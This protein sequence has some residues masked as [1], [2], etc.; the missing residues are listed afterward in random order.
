MYE[1]LEI[2]ISDYVLEE[3][4]KIIWRSKLEFTD[5]NPSTI[6]QRALKSGWVHVV[7]AINTYLVGLIMSK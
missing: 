3:S 1:K 6:R 5:Q 4:L 2:Q 7:S